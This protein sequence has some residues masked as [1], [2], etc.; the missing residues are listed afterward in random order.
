MPLHQSAQVKTDIENL[1]G[2]TMRDT[3][4]GMFGWRLEPCAQGNRPIPAPV[5]SLA[6]LRE[7]EAPVEVSVRL[8]FD[9]QLLSLAGAHIYPDDMRNSPDMFTDM[10]AEIANILAGRLKTYLNR[11]GLALMLASTAAVTHVPQTTSP[12]LVDTAFEYDDGRTP[13]PLGI[14]VRIDMQEAV[15]AA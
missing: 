2:R 13:R 5:H 15:S 12:V 8:D 6:Q 3:F 9:P 14:V 4:E 1:V 11:Q 7:A 10:A